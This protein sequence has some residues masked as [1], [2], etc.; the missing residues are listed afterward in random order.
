MSEIFKLKNKEGEK[1]FFACFEE[2]LPSHEN[3]K[4][5]F[6]HVFHLQTQAYNTLSMLCC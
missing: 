6:Q 4:K 2:P 5:R 3:Y 1:F